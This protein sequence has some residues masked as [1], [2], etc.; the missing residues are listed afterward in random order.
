MGSSAYGLRLTDA[1]LAELG[2][3]LGYDGA[4]FK[5][6]LEGGWQQ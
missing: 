6:R 3:E 1:M 4:S 5:K 2:S